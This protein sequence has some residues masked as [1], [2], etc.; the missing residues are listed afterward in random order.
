MLCLRLAP[1]GDRSWVGGLSRGASL[2]RLDEYYAP[3]E[4][5]AHQQPEDGRVVALH[6]HPHDAVEQYRGKR[7][8]SN[9]QDTPH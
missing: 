2:L 8:A 5:R 7:G 9:F 4:I 1:G 6:G 3:Q